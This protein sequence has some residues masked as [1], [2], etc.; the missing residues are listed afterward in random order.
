MDEELNQDLDQ[1]VDV[2]VEDMEEMAPQLLDLAPAAV[3]AAQAEGLAAGAGGLGG[4][5]QR[6]GGLGAAHQALLQ[7]ESPAGFQPYLRPP[8]FPLRILLL[9]VIMCISLSLASIVFLTLPG[10]PHLSSKRNVTLDL[11]Q[12]FLLVSHTSNLEDM[13]AL[14]TQFIN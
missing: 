3:G 2:D 14:R 12:N 11:N 4:M 7:R 8:L 9:L 1:D 5:F 6:N 13:L 10:I